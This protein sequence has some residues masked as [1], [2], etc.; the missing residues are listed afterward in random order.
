ML[1][2]FAS[3]N[4]V[5]LEADEAELKGETPFVAVDGWNVGVSDAG[6]AA[7][8]VLNTNAQV[9]H[10]PVTGIPIVANTWK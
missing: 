7:P 10:W 4:Y 2:V 5:S 3:E 1:P 8:V 6:S 9:D